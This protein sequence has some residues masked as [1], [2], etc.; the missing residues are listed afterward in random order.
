[1]LIGGLM[2]FV[3]LAKTS[4]YARDEPVE[5]FVSFWP[6]WFLAFLCLAWPVTS[7]IIHRR[8][9]KR[10]FPVIQ[11]EVSDQKSEV[12]QSLVESAT[13]APPDL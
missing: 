7:F 1:M 6:I 13:N 8:R 10:G 4:D 2:S 5:V 3:F 12:S 11:P 9:N